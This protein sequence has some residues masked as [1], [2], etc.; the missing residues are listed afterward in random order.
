VIITNLSGTV[1]II[2]TNAPA[3]DHRFYRARQVPD[4]RTSLG[5][6]R[7]YNV[8][9]CEECVATFLLNYSIGLYGWDWGTPE[10]AEEAADMGC[11]LG[12]PIS[13]A[14]QVVLLYLFEG[15]P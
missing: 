2:D 5:A 15:T 13:C 8:T 11:G 14:Q 10:D 9:A 4:F 12:S 6:C 3:L 1:Q 7:N